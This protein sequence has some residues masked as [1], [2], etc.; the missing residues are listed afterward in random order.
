MSRLGKKP[1]II[2]TGTEI[3]IAPTE[4]VVKGPL[5]ELKKRYDSII[6]IEVK[7]N[8]VIL[9][10]VRKS[11][12][13]SALWGTIASHIMNM[14][15]G[16]NK[17]YEKKLVIEGIGYKAEIKGEDIILNLGFSHQ[18]KIKIPKGLKLTSE[19][20][21]VSVSGIDKDLV[22][23]FAAEI[24]ALKKPEPYKGKGVHYSDE[25]VKRKEGKKTA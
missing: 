3:K 5:G 16:V 19:K 14:I 12:E 7:D 21:V 10:P 9:T 20:G 11:L 13:M 15:E 2:P 17:P 23:R 1:I 24:R 4:V 25:I 6:K 22:G 8:Q 18:I